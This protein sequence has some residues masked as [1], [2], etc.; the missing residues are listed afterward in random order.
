MITILAS[1]FIFCFCWHYYVSQQSSIG[2]SQLYHYKIF[3]G[4]RIRREWILLVAHNCLFVCFP[5][6]KQINLILFFVSKPL[7]NL[8]TFR[9]LSSSSFYPKRHP[10]GKGYAKRFTCLPFPFS[11][12]PLSLFLTPN[13]NFSY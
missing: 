9:A 7:T 13:S 10:C 2:G 5:I 11:L 8:G 6:H 4:S 12:N 3:L 1:F